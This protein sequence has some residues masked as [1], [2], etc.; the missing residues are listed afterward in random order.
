MSTYIFILGKDR[1]LSLAELHARYPNG[2]FDGDG[3]F[4]ILEIDQKIDQSEFNHLGGVI[5]VG[6]LVAIVNRNNLSNELTQQLIAHHSGSKLNYGISVYGW[7]EK[8]LR[9]LL[10]DMKRNLKKEGV[11][12]RFINQQFK[13]VSTAQYKGLK[14]KGIELLVAVH[15]DDFLIAKVI[16]VQDIDSYSERDFEKPFR[17][18]RVGMLPPKLAQIMINLAGDSKT[19]WDPFCGGGVLV[20]EGLLMGRNML[21]SD[22]N[23]ETFEGAKKNVDWL[24]KDAD[25]F[26]HDATQPLKG[27][28]FDAIV[29]EGYL[30]PP[31][32]RLQS[33]DRLKPLLQELDELYVGFFNALVEINFKGSIVIAL[34][35]FRCIGNQELDLKSTIEKIEKM[36][37]VLNPKI[38]KYARHDQVVGRAIYRFQY[39]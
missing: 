26:L 7:S 19:I 2:K 32:T 17:D 29:C 4:E 15:G 22:I 8:N 20:M 16:A 11:S 30:G 6:E 21:G 23:P 37:F 34:P 1:N 3:D 13:N 27:K 14:G 9:S 36:G 25:L 18:M 31:Q 28:K 5:K 12:S 24:G 33:P 39:R 10:L 38:L 35:F